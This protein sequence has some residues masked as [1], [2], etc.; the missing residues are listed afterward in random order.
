MIVSKEDNGSLMLHG[1]IDTNNSD[2]FKEELFQCVEGM[3][4]VVLDLADLNYVSSTGLRV[5]LKL[6]KTVKGD[7]RLINASNEIYDIFSVTGF[8]GMMDISKKL[9]NVSIEGCE[10]IGEGA[11]GKVYRLDNETIVKVFNE[12]VP[13]QVVREEKAYAT[14]AFIAGVPT[15]IS[16]D[17]V[18]CGNSFGAVYELLDAKTVSQAICAEPERTAEYGKNM[19]ALLKRL[20]E[21]YA[22]TSV[23][24]NIQELY[25]ERVKSLEKYYDKKDVDLLLDIYEKLP[26][27]DTVLHGDFHTKNI[28]ISGDEMLFIDMG[29]VGYGNP[30]F[31]IG[32]SYLGLINIGKRDPSMC[33]RYIGI[34][35]EKCN[36][37]W[38][39]LLKT[40]FETEDIEKFTK[41][42][43]IFGDAKYATTP[44]FYTK[45]DE[46]VVKH[47]YNESKT[48][49][50]FREG[51]DLSVLEEVFK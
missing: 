26:K 33:P 21:T 19:G 4:D 45:A 51:Y 50:I 47:V 32:G 16:Y 6:K 20:H 17:V 10:V 11:N 24:N 48:R 2:Q 1:R 14:S 8:T 34:D 30:W 22:D 40:Y 43:S 27:R 9:R 49:G 15:A 38:E 39:N 35:F 46:R 3:D 23:L 44:A 41:I 36:I 29:D 42:A 7:L 31:D 18:R 5:F 13:E 25:I 12:R 28:M 37:V